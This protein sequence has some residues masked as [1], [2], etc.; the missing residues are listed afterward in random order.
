MPIFFPEEAE[1]TESNQNG[2]VIRKPVA[3]KG[4]VMSP[5]YNSSACKVPAPIPGTM[6][7]IQPIPQPDLC[8]QRVGHPSM[9]PRTQSV[10]GV[11]GAPFSLNQGQPLPRDT[12]NHGTVR[13]HPRYPANLSIMNPA[14]AAAAVAFHHV[15]PNKYGKLKFD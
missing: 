5:D 7:L 4:H 3:A 11:P 10:A 1:K 8:P 14:S 6:H 12:S 15:R 13:H 2:P 9:D